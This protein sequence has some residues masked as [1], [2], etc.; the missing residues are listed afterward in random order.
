MGVAAP[1]PPESN[2]DLLA[3]FSE[4]ERQ[5]C[6]SCGERASVTIPEVVA[7]FCLSCGAITIDGLRIDVERRLPFGH[8]RSE[9]TW[10]VEAAGFS[11]R[12]VPIPPGVAGRHP[13]DPEE[14][15]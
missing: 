2:V 1:P 4:D 12:Q 9:D 13:T 3:W 6:A 8:D 10:D 7:L 14:S 11:P 15:L 5:A